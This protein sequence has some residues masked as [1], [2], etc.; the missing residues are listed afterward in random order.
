MARFRPRVFEAPTQTWEAQEERVAQSVARGKRV[1]GSG[2]SMYAKGDVKTGEFLIEC[3]FTDKASLS[4]KG[5][6]LK[7]I[8]AEAHA[9]GKDPALA[10]Q[11]NGVDAR[12]LMEADWVA[13]P[14]SVFKRLTESDND[15][16]QD[17]ETD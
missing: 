3:K 14:M 6:W 12:G 1:T 8:T 9:I 4:I 10:I 17:T 13:I 7:K 2:R 16:Q 15:T 5:E 11:I